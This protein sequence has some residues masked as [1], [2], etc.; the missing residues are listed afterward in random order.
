MSTSASSWKEW[1]RTS[2]ESA[3][4][5]DCEFLILTSSLFCMS[6]QDSAACTT[7]YYAWQLHLALVLS[8][9]WVMKKVLHNL[10]FISGKNKQEHQNWIVSCACAVLQTCTTAG[11]HNLQNWLLCTAYTISSAIF[12]FMG[13]MRKALVNPMF[14][15]ADV[16]FLSLRVYVYQI[17]QK[18][19]TLCIH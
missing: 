1:T 10:N 17:I 9:K 13:A 14:L 2:F 19:N 3:G 18:G 4:G 5:S 11:L 6:L 7:G 16:Y 8:S 15:P 12:C